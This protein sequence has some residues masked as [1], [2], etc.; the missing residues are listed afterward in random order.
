MTVRFKLS[1]AGQKREIWGL[2]G[3]RAVVLTDSSTSDLA[4][5]PPP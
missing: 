3:E 2:V 5:S 4:N 1:D